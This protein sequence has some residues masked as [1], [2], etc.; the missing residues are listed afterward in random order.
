MTAARRRAGESLTTALSVGQVPH[1]PARN[2]KTLPESVSVP[3]KSN[4]A[5]VA[6]PGGDE[7]PPSP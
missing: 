7:P 5:T 6:R 4:A 1:T 3:S 2:G